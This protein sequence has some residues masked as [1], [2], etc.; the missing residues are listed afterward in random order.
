MRPDPRWPS[1]IV[2]ASSKLTS[3]GEKRVGGPHRSFT[4]GML[5]VLE[6]IG[7]QSE[8]AEVLVIARR[9]AELEM[10]PEGWSKA[11]GINRK[12]INQRARQIG[13]RVTYSTVHKAKGTEADYII[14]LDGGPPKAGQAAKA[15]AFERALRCSVERC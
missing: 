10:P 15:R 2:I 7:E 4:G 3:E 8:G 14:L 9:N 12:G 13:V 6:R 5:A 1:S 11:T